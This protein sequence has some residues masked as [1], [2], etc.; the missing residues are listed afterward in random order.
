MVSFCPQCGAEQTDDAAFCGSC[1]SKLATA[2]PV[3]PPPPPPVTPPTA[4]KPKGRSVFKMVLYGLGAVGLLFIGMVVY[5]LATDKNDKPAAKAPAQTQ[6]QQPQQQAQQPQ[7]QPA[8]QPQQQAQQPQQPQ[9][10]PQQQVQQ[11]APAAA[12]RA[13]ALDLGSGFDNGRFAVT[14]ATDSF[15]AARLNVVHAV[16]HIEGVTSPVMVKTEWMYLGTRES[17][18]SNDIKME[19]NGAAHFELS[20]PAKGWPAGEFAIKVYIN[21]KETGYRK[22]IIR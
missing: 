18:W 20:K 10:Q 14:G 13:V 8:Q 4:A 15:Q 17:V 19:D 22:F 1:G 16:V 9:R 5:S 3:G 21:G 2:K 12:A 6:T 11:Q 7:Q